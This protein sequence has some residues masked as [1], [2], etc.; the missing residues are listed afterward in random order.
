KSGKR[1]EMGME[2][3]VRLEEVTP[4]EGG[5]LL[6]IVSDPKP[7]KPGEKL[8]TRMR[9]RKFERRPVRGKGKAG[10]RGKSR[11]K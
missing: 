8:P 2:V 9:G 1:Y 5:L 11:R 10:K 4:L 3:T 7:R 6:E